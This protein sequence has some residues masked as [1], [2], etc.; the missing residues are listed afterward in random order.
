MGVIDDYYGGYES[1]AFFTAEDG[2]VDFEAA[3][4]AQMPDE[5]GY[6]DSSMDPWERAF[7]YKFKQALASCA[8]PG[9]SDTGRKT[10][11]GKPVWE[12]SCSSCGKH[13]T[14]PF[15]PLAD[16]SPPKCRECHA[17]TKGN[18]LRADQQGKSSKGRSKGRNRGGASSSNAGRGSGGGSS[19]AGARGAARRLSS[20]ARL[21]HM[22]HSLTRPGCVNDA[23]RE[24][25]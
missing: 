19:M 2:V 21:Q 7:D 14:V 17:E 24:A 15:V 6:Y 9:W 5:D 10:T 12:G 13:T 20:K 3:Y 22:P 25:P 16:G 11:A 4:D 23:Q 8:L 18:S 1:L